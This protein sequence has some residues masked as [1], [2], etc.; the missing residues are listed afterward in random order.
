MKRLKT[1]IYWIVAA[2]SVRRAI[3][4]MRNI[5]FNPLVI[6]N[7][8]RWCLVI[9]CG[10]DSY[11]VKDV[12]VLTK[13]HPE[14]G[15]FLKS[16]NKNGRFVLGYKNDWSTFNIIYYKFA[17]VQSLQ[18]YRIEQTRYG[19][20]VIICT[21]HDIPLNNDT[22]RFLSGLITKLIPHRITVDE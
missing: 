10:N 1:I 13:Y 8:F 18:Q 5:V 16:A 20:E 22:K 9:D 2:L 21:L 17:L 7:E 11:L 14:I 6:S 3:A 4:M 15:K 12:A 19:N